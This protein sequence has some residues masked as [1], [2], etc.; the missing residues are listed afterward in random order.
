MTTE[1][2]AVHV[3]VL[4][5]MHIIIRVCVRAAAVYVSMT[6]RTI[7]AV[8]PESGTEQRKSEVTG[9]SAPAFLGPASCC[10]A[11]FIYEGYFLSLSDC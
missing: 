6:L 4:C 2:A 5:R 3:Y 10:F 8:N 7:N 11:V 1:S 9:R